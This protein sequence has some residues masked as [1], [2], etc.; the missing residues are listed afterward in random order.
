MDSF[1]DSDKWKFLIDN[2]VPWEKIIPLYLNDFPTDSGIKSPEEM[3]ETVWEILTIISKWSKEKIEPRAKEFDKKGPGTLRD[4]ATIPNK[5][6]SDLFK[7]AN[8]LG[9]HSISINPIYGG[10]GLP[11]IAY[12]LAFEQ[13]ARGC[14]SSSSQLTFFWPIADMIERFGNYEQ[15]E[16]YIP[17]LTSGEWS[18]SMCITEPQAGSDVGAISTI[19]KKVDDQT[20]VLNGGKIFITNGG[21]D[22]A[23]VLARTEKS[24]EGLKGLSLFLVERTV[25]KNG[26]KINNF[27]VIKIEEKMAQKGCFTC[28]VVYENT[29]GHLLGEENKGFTYMLHLM[30][31]S[32]IG[33]GL[34]GLAGIESCLEYTREYASTRVQFGR[35]LIDIP[36]FKRNFSQWETERDALR[37]LIVDTISHFDIFQKLD[38]KKKHT[39]DL[40]KDEEKLLNESLKLVRKRTPL[41]KYYGAEAFCEISKKCIQALGGHGFIKDH[42]VERFHRESF[43]PLLYEGTSQIQALMSVKDLLK[44][45]GKKPQVIFSSVVKGHPTLNF[46]GD[47]SSLKRHFNKVNYELKKNIGV[48]ILKVLNPLTKDKSFK[49]VLNLFDKEAWYEQSNLDELM[50][51]AETICQSFIYQETFRA[52][53]K[54][55]ELGSEQEKLY[56]DYYKLVGPRLRAIYEDWKQ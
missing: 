6:L 35:A 16:K 30:N 47:N 10:M 40:N 12:L 21:A 48:L 2:F 7:E 53:V 56:Y 31:E 14:L 34:Q 44:T 45:I 36:L 54:Y 8:E 9:F 5:L 49:N 15:K 25:K 18:G 38:L 32:R 19:A 46:L 20:F 26:E 22:L 1:K 52:L 4:G 28:Q 55:G 39:G 13:V 43:G 29:I 24:E 37:V 27:E 3:K 50:C 33:C 42:F 51:H 11:V 41:I 23:L 17:K